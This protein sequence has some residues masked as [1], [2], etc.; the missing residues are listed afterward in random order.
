MKKHIC[1]TVCLLDNEQITD[2]HRNGNIWNMRLE[3]S[4][5]NMQKI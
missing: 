1:E 4:Q 2:E 3:T 5:K